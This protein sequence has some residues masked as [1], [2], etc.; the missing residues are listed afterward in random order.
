MVLESQEIAP[1][2]AERERQRSSLGGGAGKQG[3]A[4]IKADVEHRTKCGC[5]W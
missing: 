5:F 1:H 4:E 2:R 3:R